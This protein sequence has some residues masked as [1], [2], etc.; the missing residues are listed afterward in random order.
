MP[1]GVKSIVLCRVSVWKGT[2]FLKNWSFVELL[3]C[4]FRPF[5]SIKSQ[6][7]RMVLGKAGE[8]SEMAPRLS[9]QSRNPSLQ[10]GG[11][12]YTGGMD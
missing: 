9:L 12:V 3:A 11:C 2:A 7:Q 5:R 1:A 8:E 6:H 4:M 10:G